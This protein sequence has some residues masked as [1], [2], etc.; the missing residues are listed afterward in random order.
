MKS[1][2]LS[3]NNKKEEHWLDYSKIKFSDQLVEDT[4]RV[5]SVLIMYLPLFIYWAL[6]NQ[7]MSRWVFQAS[8]MNGDVGF[9]TIKP[10]QMVMVGPLFVLILLPIFKSFVFPL[11]EKCGLRTPLKKMG[12]GMFLAV[13][14]FLCS[15][16]VEFFIHRSYLSV[17]W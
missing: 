16:C 7:Q 1:K 9:Y 3:K 2:F 5:L 4:K 13:V 14:T 10:D 15:A 11:L 8:L 17:L 12:I 6:L